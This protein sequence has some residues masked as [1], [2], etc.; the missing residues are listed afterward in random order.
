MKQ[1]LAALSA[2]A[3]VG[4]NA[5]GR[6]DLTAVAPPNAPEVKS[7]GHAGID[8]RIAQH[9]QNASIPESLIH[10][11]VKRES[12]YN[13]M[14]K[15]GP[16]WGLMQIRYDTARSMGYDGPASGL[17]D[18]ETNLK[19]GVAYLANAWRLAG[20]DERRAIQLYAGGYYYE[21]KRR[22]MLGEMRKADDFAAA[23]DTQTTRVARSEPKRSA[24]ASAMLAQTETP[25]APQAA[26]APSE[27]TASQA[28][29]F[30]AAETPAE[31]GAIPALI[32]ALDAAQR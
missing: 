4:C 15:H 14:C 9:A 1:A 25:P 27:P 13:P 20:G 11:S 16:Y 30:A 19:Y 21:A 32:S 6:Q 18:A 29:A 23:A 5:A 28:S 12:N 31:P 3:L 26:A 24:P 10:R 2:L 17:L 22:G 8:A 7:A